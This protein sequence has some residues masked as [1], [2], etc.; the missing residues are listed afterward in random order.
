MD[1]GDV[2]T[3]SYREGKNRGTVKGNLLLFLGCMEKLKRPWL[4]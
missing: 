4:D 3:F 2:I 1:C